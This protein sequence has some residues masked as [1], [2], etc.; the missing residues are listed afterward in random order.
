MSV[1]MGCAMRMKAMSMVFCA[2]FV[3]GALGATPSAFA[4]DGRAEVSNAFAYLLSTLAD[5]ESVLSENV[6]ISNSILSVEGAKGGFRAAKADYRL[7]D[8]A[9]KSIEEIRQYSVDREENMSRYGDV[10]RSTEIIPEYMTVV[11]SD[12]KD[13]VFQYSVLYKRDLPQLSEEG[14][15]WV[16]RVEYD[17]EFGGGGI[18]ENIIARNLNYY[19]QQEDDFENILPDNALMERLERSTTSVNRSSIVSYATKY[20]YNYNPAYISYAAQRADCTNFASQAMY[21]G[22]WKKNYEWM[23]N[24]VATTNA[25]A[26]ADDFY[27]Y[28]LGRSLTTYAN[29]IP[30]SGSPYQTMRTGDLMFFT[31]SGS[32]KIK[33]AM[34]ITKIINGE[35]YLTY[36]SNDNLNAPF[37]SIVTKVEP[38]TSFVTLNVTP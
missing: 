10:V 8:N 30:V 12:S 34:I 36:H 1:E 13:S 21:A 33:H 20:A 25:W 7:S 28:G 29:M 16:E 15:E 18:I 37:S 11:S 6:E 14:D 5:V 38:N 19:L 3:I 23:G 9:K 35:A 27:W 4:L 24:D 26:V 22:G 17:V 31:Y 32:R 2:L